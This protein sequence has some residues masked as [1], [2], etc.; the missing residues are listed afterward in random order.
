MYPEVEHVQLFG[1][2]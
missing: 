1:Y 2:M